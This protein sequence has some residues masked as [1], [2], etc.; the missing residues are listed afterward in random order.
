MAR[1]AIHRAGTAENLAL[2]SSVYGPASKAFAK[3]LAPCP[4]CGKMLV[5]GPVRKHKAH[6]SFRAANP[7]SGEWCP[8]RDG[9]WK[10]LTFFVQKR[11]RPYSNVKPPPWAW[12][13][14]WQREQAK[15]N[16]DADTWIAEVRARKAA[17]AG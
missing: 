12:A 15:R 6:P 7:D 14:K 8:Q 17:H 11:K 1:A 2:G 3:P 9:G 10:S 4:T 5:A 13:K 16:A